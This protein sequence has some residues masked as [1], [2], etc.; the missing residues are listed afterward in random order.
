[1]L[2]RSLI[3]LLSLFSIIPLV[4]FDGRP[5]RGDLSVRLWHYG[6]LVP[7]GE[8]LD[9]GVVPRCHDGSEDGILRCYNTKEELAA[10]VGFDLPGVDQATVERFRASG[11]VISSQATYYAIVWEHP[12]F[13]GRACALSQDH[14]DFRA[15]AFDNMTS[16]IWIPAGAGPSIYYDNVNYV[17]PGW[18]F[19]ASVDD[20]NRA[21]CNDVISSARRLRY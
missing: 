21:G 8:L 12:G 14:P 18:V 20:L 4:G 10:A 13:E 17:G 7:L 16:S 6:E 5:A 9:E 15:I 2:R 19:Y 3:V 1:M 11:A